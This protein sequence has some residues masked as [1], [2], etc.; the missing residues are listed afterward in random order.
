MDVSPVVVRPATIAD[1]DPVHAIYAPYVQ[2]SV[3]SFEESVPDIDEIA[4]RM[5]AQPRLPWFAACQGDQ[6]VGYAY[7][8]H[9]RSRRAYRWAVEVSVYVG[10]A[11]QG[12]GIGTLLY[13]D[14]LEEL[15]ALGYVSA[16]AGIALPN[17]PSVRLHES[18]GFT[19]IGAFRAAGFKLGQWHDVGWWQ[20]PLVTPPAAPLEP[21]AWAQG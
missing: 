4:R 1:A 18:L 14:L 8:A 6:V 3:V 7:G 17:Q 20:L 16:F 5:L 10:A 11:W 19:R 15:R 12:K 2:D 21:R 9:H 13:R